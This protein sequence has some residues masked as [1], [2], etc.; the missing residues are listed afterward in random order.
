MNMQAP[1]PYPAASWIRGGIWHL[2][3]LHAAERAIWGGRSFFAACDDS[4]LSVSVQ[5]PTFVLFAV[6]AKHPRRMV[7]ALDYHGM[8]VC[9][10]SPR[11]HVFTLIRRS[12]PE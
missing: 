8:D 1:I 9:Y 12:V 2:R 6:G 11:A 4:L 10:V 7:H 5:M 3:V